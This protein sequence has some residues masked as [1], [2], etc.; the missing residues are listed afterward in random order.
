MVRRGSSSVEPP[1]PVCHCWCGNLGRGVGVDLDVA[2]SYVE[3][4][5]FALSLRGVGISN[6][7][8][9][10]VRYG[11]AWNAATNSL[12]FRRGSRPFARARAGRA[13][14][15]VTLLADGADVN[16]PK[17]DGSGVTALLVTCQEG[18]AEVSS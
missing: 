15:V 18:H 14:D 13:A 1:S 5:S 9:W 7:G 2:L 17:T 16:E 3:A 12:I 6:R 8:V 11:R 10:C 4:P